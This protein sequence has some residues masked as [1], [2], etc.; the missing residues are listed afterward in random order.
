MDNL[1]GQSVNKQN[2]GI[3]ILFNALAKKIY[4]EEKFWLDEALAIYICRK[5]RVITCWKNVNNLCK[6]ICSMCIFSME[7]QC[8]CIL[9]DFFRVLSKLLWLSVYFMNGIFQGWQT[10]YSTQNT[11]RWPVKALTLS[12]HQKLLSFRWVF[13]ATLGVRTLWIPGFRFDHNWTSLANSN[14]PRLF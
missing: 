13:P 11:Q 10:W 12:V 2:I 1:H 14:R 4:Y 8:T 6:W 7:Y 3:M 9:G 5:L